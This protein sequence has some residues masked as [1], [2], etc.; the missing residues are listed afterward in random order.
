[1][2]S[3]RTAVFVMI[4]LAV[5][6]LTGLLPFFKFSRMKAMEPLRARA[7]TGI[8]STAAGSPVTRW[9][10]GLPGTK[11]DRTLS[12]LSSASGGTGKKRPFR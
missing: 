2:A 7:A 11:P 8:L 12:P 6:L 1:M 5:A 10:A 3:W 9:A 4:I